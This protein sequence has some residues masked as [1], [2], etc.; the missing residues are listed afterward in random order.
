M[1]TYPVK[2]CLLCPFVAPTLKYLLKHLRQVHAHQPGFNITCCLSG[3]QRKF[4]T[5]EVFRNHIYEAHSESENIVITQS[6]LPDPVS[7]P[8]LNPDPYPVPNP[9]P[10][11][12]PPTPELTPDPDCDPDPHSMA[13]ERKKRSATWILKI[14]EKFKLPQSTIEQIIQDVTGFFEDLLDDLYDDLKSILSNAGVDH[15]TITGLS[16]L[17]SSTSTYSKPFAGLETQYLQL[18]FY[19]KELNF[20]VCLGVKYTTN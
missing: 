6:T 16:E 12:E 13:N 10:P 11:A 15:S 19:K 18:K 7:N 17:F 2:P 20:V 3:C 8:V 14:Q 4:R 9:Y 5:F 1:S